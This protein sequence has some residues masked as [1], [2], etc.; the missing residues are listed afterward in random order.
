MTELNNVPENKVPQQVE[1][2]ILAGLIK[3]TIERQPDGDW[4]IK[5]E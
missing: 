2:F 4:T 1:I 3:I 5:G